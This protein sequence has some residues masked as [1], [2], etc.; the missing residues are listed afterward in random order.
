MSGAKISTLRELLGCE[1]SSDLDRQIAEVMNQTIPAYLIATETPEQREKR[2]RKACYDLP[3]SEQSIP[4]RQYQT[5]EGEIGR[6][7]CH[8]TPRRRGLFCRWSYL[9]LRSR[10]SLRR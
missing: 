2:I 10:E 6:C 1:M 8:F 3:L 5:R 4:P 9:S 7:C